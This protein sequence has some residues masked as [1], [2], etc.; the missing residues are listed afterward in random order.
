M[1]QSMTEKDQVHHTVCENYSQLHVEDHMYCSQTGS[2]KR[3]AWITEN[4]NVTAVIHYICHY[5]DNSLWMNLQIVM[6]FE[7]V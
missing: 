7:N 2:A 3:M 6:W 5:T 1:E 4:Y